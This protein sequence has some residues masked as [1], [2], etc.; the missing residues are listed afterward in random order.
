MPKTIMVLTKREFMSRLKNRSL[1]KISKGCGVSYPTLRRIQKGESDIINL[2]VLKKV[3]DFLG[4]K[5]G[6]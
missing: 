6:Q 2:S 5:N 1:V 3:T 4:V